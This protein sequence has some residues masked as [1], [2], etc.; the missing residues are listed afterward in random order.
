MAGV[1]RLLPLT[2][3]TLPF[4]SYGGSSLLANYVLLALLL[5]ISNDSAGSAARTIDAAAAR[6]SECG[7]DDQE[8]S[9][10][11]R[12]IGVFLVVC[13]AALFFQVNRLT[14]F[15]ADELKDNPANNREVERDFSSP[16]VDHHRR[17]HGRRPLG[18]PRTISSS[19][20]ASTTR[21][22]CS[23]TSP[24][25]SPSSWGRRASSAATTTSWR[26]A[27][28]TSTCR[29]LTCSSTASGWAT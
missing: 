7:G 14:I 27:R 8:P 22:A 29:S 13:Y 17:R 19:C 5:R 18:A 9:K 6:M 11:I 28:S 1:T 23:P 20:N 2:G 4:I 16:G 21:R 12:N 26:G 15:Q 24:A 10:Q 25:T 3:V